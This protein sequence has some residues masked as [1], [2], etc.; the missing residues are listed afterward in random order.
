VY[1]LW[2][3]VADRFIYVP[4]AAVAVLVGLA[5]V[6]TVESRRSWSRLRMWANVLVGVALVAWIAGGVWMLHARGQLWLGAGQQAQTIVDGVQ[7]L[8]PDP[9]PNAVIVVLGVP[10]ET[11]PAIPPSNTGPYVFHN[12]LDSAIH[13]AYDRY[14]LTVIVVRD[15]DATSAPPGAYVF[16]YRD[17]SI[18]RVA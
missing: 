15:A 5:L 2:P 14:D 11:V 1:T 17:G 16:D 4:D 10:D 18:V 12:G 7:R 9:P 13:L 8:L 3:Y 6:R